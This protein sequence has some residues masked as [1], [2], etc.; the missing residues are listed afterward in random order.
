[1]RELQVW[2]LGRREYVATVA[3]QEELVR[4]RR[5]GEIPDTLLL[6]EHEAVITAG[7]AHPTGPPPALR[8]DPSPRG[9]GDVSEPSVAVKMR[10][11]RPNGGP[12]PA[13]RADPSPQGRGI[14]IEPFVATNEPSW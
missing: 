5:A 11:R 1:M 14:G 4:R 7:R 13:L 3:L 8:A 10:W 6:L 2:R 12:P 9:R